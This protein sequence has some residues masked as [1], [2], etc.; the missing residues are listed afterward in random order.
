MMR[1]VCFLIGLSLSLLPLRAQDGDSASKPGAQEAAVPADQDAL[2]RVLTESLSAVT[3]IDATYD[4]SSQV[5]P[6]YETRQII[7]DFVSGKFLIRSLHFRDP[8]R[9]VGAGC[10]IES[11]DGEQFVR[12][13]S[14]LSDAS[15]ELLAKG[16]SILMGSAVVEAS[17]NRLDPILSSRREFIGTGSPL[18]T[19][20]RAIAEGDYRFPSERVLKVGSYEVEFLLGG[21]PG[22]IKMYGDFGRG[23]EVRQEIV[24]GAYGEIDGKRIPTAIEVR[25]LPIGGKKDEWQDVS[26]TRLHPST[27]KLNMPL[28]DEAFRFRFPSGTR[29]QDNVKGVSYTVPTDPEEY[30]GRDSKNDLPLGLADMAK[31]KQIWAKSLLGQKGPDVVVEKWLTPAPDLKGKF[32]LVDFWATWCGPCLKSIPGLNEI[33]GKFGDKLTVVGITDEDE[34]K[35]RALKVPAIKYAHGIDPQKRMATALEIKGYPHVILMDPQGIV[36]WEGFPLLSGQELTNQAVA[37]IISKYGK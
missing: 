33:Q 12:F 8:E 32:V 31:D 14:G 22:V 37:E 6:R 24:F 1:H 15:F 16:G 4:F 21:E 3:S 13:T 11:W 26:H 35:V 30:S 25:F 36:R 19:I 5:G 28:G 9:K 23:P 7:A 29:V 34:E 10:S 2:L 27:V 17:P 18:D 20:Q